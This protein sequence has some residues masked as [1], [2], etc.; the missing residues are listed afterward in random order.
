MRVHHPHPVVAQTQY[1]QA[2]ERLEVTGVQHLY[3]V[4]LNRQLL[5]SA[6]ETETTNTQSSTHDI[7]YDTFSIKLINMAIGC[8]A[9]K[10]VAPKLWNA[11]PNEVRTI[12][13]GTMLKDI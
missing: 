9:F 1:A 4:A 11:L 2:G 10:I 5:R 8:R 6:V 13:E 3:P 12:E 7:V